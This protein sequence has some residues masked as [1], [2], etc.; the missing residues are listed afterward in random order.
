MFLARESEGFME[1]VQWFQQFGDDRV[2]SVETRPAAR[3]R[4]PVRRA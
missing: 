1:A 3:R 2:A 4:A